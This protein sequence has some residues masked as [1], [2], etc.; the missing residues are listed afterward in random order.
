MAKAM[1]NEDMKRKIK[2]LEKKVAELD[3]VS[4]S[5]RRLPSA[6]P[7]YYR[8]ASLYH[9][10]LFINSYDSTGKTFHPYN[11]ITDK[12]QNVELLN[13][14]ESLSIE[15]ID[16]YVSGTDF[17]IVQF[18]DDKAVQLNQSG[19]PIVEG[20][21]LPDSRRFEIFPV[22]ATGSVTAMRIECP[23]H[24]RESTFAVSDKVTPLFRISGN[25]G[26]KSYCFVKAKFVG[27][28]YLK[29]ADIPVSDAQRHFE[30]LSLFAE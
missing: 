12:P 17:M 4:G 21:G 15:H 6:P 18:Y 5:M 3:D 8:A 22:G 10:R 24:I 26:A 19:N 11:L 30:A 14:F 7:Q 25:A 28:S 23:K 20:Y 2:A 1:S 13:K 27:Y 29:P 16:L 9:T